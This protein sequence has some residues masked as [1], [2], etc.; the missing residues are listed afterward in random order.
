MMMM[1]MMMMILETQMA[2]LK[3]NTWLWANKSYLSCSA[4]YHHQIIYNIYQS[5]KESLSYIT[6]KYLQGNPQTPMLFFSQFCPNEYLKLALCEVPLI[7]WRKRQPIF[8]LF[9]RFNSLEWCYEV[10]ICK[11]KNNVIVW[12]SILKFGNFKPQKHL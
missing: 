11:R 5:Q 3:I 6:N 2:A 12:I 1:M 8:E 10:D 7:T 9:Y 4:I